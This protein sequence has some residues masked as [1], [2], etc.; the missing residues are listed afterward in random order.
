ML[1]RADDFPIHQT[2]EPI[3]V[4]GSD[5]NFYDR[6]FFNG[7]DAKGDVMFAI[8]LGVYPVLNIMDAALT[9]AVDGQQHNLRFSKE[10]LGERLDMQVG[11]FRLNVVEPLKTLRIRI[12]DNEH[13]IHGELTCEARHAAMLE[14]RFVQRLGPRTLLDYTRL[15]QNI[16]WS[17]QLSVAGKTYQLEGWWGTRDRSWGVRPVGGGD[18]QPPVPAAE[19]QFYWLWNAMNCDDLSLF[20]LSSEDDEGVPSNRLGVLMAQGEEERFAQPHYELHY[21]SGTRRVRAL[22]LRMDNG[23]RKLSAR[24]TLPGPKLYMSGLGYLHPTWGHGTHHGPLAMQYDCY[25][26]DELEAQLAQGRLEY[27]H[28]Q[29]KC[30]VELDLDGRRHQGRGVLEQ[31]FLGKHAPSGFREF[32]DMAS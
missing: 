11:A 4:A 20:F 2:A 12:A 18:S 19:P 29:A 14:P 6:Y 3:A 16:V 10:L 26:L 13:K 30:G 32:L 5:R 21:E 22:T 28:V 15:T 17:G 8:A 25:A 9:V 27:L 1:T 31:L 23:R 7:Y 24:L